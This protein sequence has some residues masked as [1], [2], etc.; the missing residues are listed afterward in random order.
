LG[1]TLVR[2]AQTAPGY[3]L[4]VL[5]GVT[6]P[7]PGLVRAKGFEGP[8]I[9]VEV[10][11]LPVAAFARFVE[12]IPSPLGIGKIRLDDGSEVSGFLGEADAVRGA[13]EITALGGWRAYM[14]TRTQLEPT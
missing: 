10:W 5:P 12:A 11:A 1:G 3:R 9:A 8:G 6:P 7:K 2:S 4:F 14:A 13:E